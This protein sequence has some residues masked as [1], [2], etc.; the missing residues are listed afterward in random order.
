MAGRLARR[1]E[2]EGNKGLGYIEKTLAVNLRM[3][4]QTG[5]GVVE[6]QHVRVVGATGSGVM[7]M[8]E[9]RRRL[10]LPK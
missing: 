10:P 2:A 5:D 9:V 4:Y 6:D 7:H 1:E 3:A 8:A